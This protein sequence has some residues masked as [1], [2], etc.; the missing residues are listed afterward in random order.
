MQAIQKYGEGGGRRKRLSK[1]SL[2]DLAGSERAYKTD[3][4]GQRL[5]EGRNINRSLLSLANCINALADKTKRS[6]FIPYRDSKLTRLLRDS[7]SG[8]S[9]ST[10]ICAVSPASDQFDEALNTL[11]YA[12]RAKMMTPPQAPAT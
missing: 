11:K 5:V 8:S 1:L 3:N 2:I 4:R 10:M 6:S 12:N 9:V 7:L